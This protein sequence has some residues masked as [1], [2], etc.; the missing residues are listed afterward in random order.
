MATKYHIVYESL[1]LKVFYPGQLIMSVNQRSPLCNE[2]NDY[3]Q[4]GPSKFRKEIDSK[5][6]KQSNAESNTENYT[7]FIKG[8]TSTPD[9]P[10]LARLKN[11]I[12]NSKDTIT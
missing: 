9:T 5:I 11:S 4:D 1:E 2:Y 12:V 10:H 8:I 7:G 6:Q 3:Y